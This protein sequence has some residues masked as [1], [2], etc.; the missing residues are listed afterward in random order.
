[1]RY[2]GKPAMIFEGDGWET[3][4]NL[5]LMMN[6][7]LDMFKGEKMDK[8]N[9]SALD[10]VIVCSCVSPQSSSDDNSTLDRF[11]FRQYGILLHAS[12]STLPRV[13]LDE[14][15][16]RMDL[17]IHRVSRGSDELR[18]ASLKSVKVAK[19]KNI[20][21]TAM[22]DKVGRIHM[23]KQDLANVNVLRLKGLKRSRDEENDENDAE[24]S[25]NRVAKRVSGAGGYGPNT[26]HAN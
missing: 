5:Q 12:T 7:L 4:A 16:P 19:T 11:T 9:A 2:A 1:V 22:G 8:I 26:Q 24:T 21:R 15:G 14:V 6:L 17:R 20:E 10:R 18:K 3:N 25:S 13:E 23:K